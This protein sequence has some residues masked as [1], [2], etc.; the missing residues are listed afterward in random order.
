VD[1]NLLLILIFA[2]LAAFVF[3]RLFSVLGQKTGN[4][5]PPPPMVSDRSDSNGAEDKVVSLPRREDAPDAVPAW[6]NDGPVGAGL[7]QISLA[8]RSFDPD[9]F[10][11]GARAAFEMIIEAFHK[12][13]LE[14]VRPFLADDVYRSFAAAVADREKPAAEHTHSE[15]IAVNGCEAVAAGMEGRMASITVRFE[16]EQTEVVKDSEGRIV[17]GDLARPLEVIDVWTFAR[18]TRA[19]D[20]NWQLVAT[21]SPD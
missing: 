10:L 4:E 2:G 5:Q 16:S 21:R 15:L 17:A 12:G 19:R 3:F 7:T 8:D 20:P 14:K 9:T 11:A 6:G 13:Q 18:D 1:G